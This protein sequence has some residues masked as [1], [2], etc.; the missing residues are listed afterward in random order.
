MYFFITILIL[1]Y[2]FNL[3]CALKYN[4]LGI[5]DFIIIALIHFCIIVEI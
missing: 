3:I 1:A 4:N 5:F 2:V